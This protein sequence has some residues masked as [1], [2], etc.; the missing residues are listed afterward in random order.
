MNTKK[1]ILPMMLLVVLAMASASVSAQEVHEECIAT[2]TI[3]GVKT[4]ECFEIEN[5]PVED[6]SDQ[7]PV[8]APA[9]EEAKPE[10]F[11]APASS[12][13][14]IIAPAPD[15]TVGEE[16]MPMPI[17]PAPDATVEEGLVIMPY[18]TGE[19]VIMPHDTN[20][21]VP[22]HEKEATNPLEALLQSFAKFFSQ[23]WPF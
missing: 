7:A 11:I 12:D 22:T 18:D 8:I 17:A 10:P 9:H 2:V 14:L 20:E 19:N 23:L 4:T 5:A 13:E 3:E 1:A 16:I 15:A 21:I 6:V